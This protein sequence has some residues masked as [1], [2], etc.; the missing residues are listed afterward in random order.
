VS[1]SE[2]CTTTLPTFV[3]WPRNLSHS[4]PSKPAFT[5]AGDLS[6]IFGRRLVHDPMACCASPC[7]ECAVFKQ[8][9]FSRHD[10]WTASASMFSAPVGQRRP[11]VEAMGGW[12][13]SST[14]PR[15]SPLDS[16]F[17]SRMAPSAISCWAT[18][19]SAYPET[20]NTF[21]SG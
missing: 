2:G 8:D 9:K 6:E 7:R 18:G 17:C 21:A 11:S 15:S 3:D 1:S 16:G 20:Y 12:S 5:C 10:L 14:F 13:I 19:T 4:C